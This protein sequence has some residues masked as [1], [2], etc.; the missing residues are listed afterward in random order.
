MALGRCSS[1]RRILAALL[2]VP[3][4]I[5][6]SSTSGAGVTAS[7]EPAAVGYYLSPDGDDSADGTTP[8]SAWRTLDRASQAVLAPGEHLWL[9]GGAR[10]TGRLLLDRQD[11]GDPA[12][13]VRI[14]SFGQGRAVIE[15]PDD[16]AVVV[17][18]AA[19]VQVRDLVLTGDPA[20]IR[21]GSAGVRLFAEARDAGVLEHVHVEGI[22][23]SGFDIGI[24][25]GASE[26]GA[27][28]R[29]VRIADADLHDNLRAGLASYGPPFDAAAPRYAHEDVVI[30]R[31]RAWNN[32]GDPEV[33]EHNTGSGIVLGS[34]RDAVVTA[35]VAHD[36]GGAGG[37][38]EGP[39]GIWTYDSTGVRIERSLSY[40]NRTGSLA[41]GGGFGLDQNTSDSVLQFNLSYDNHGPGYLVYTGKDNAAH[42]GSLVRFNV[43]SGD[44]RR[45]SVYGGITALG[46]VDDVVV[47]HNTVVMA[48][49]A[50]DP[51]AALRLGP[52]VTGVV[53][54]DNVFLVARAGPVVVAEG[55]AVDGVVL[56]GNVHH[57][58]GRSW[59]V[60]WGGVVHESVTAWRAATGQETRDGAPTGS[61]A[62]PLLAGPVL[63]LTA[64][65]AGDLVALAGFAPTA[66]SPL[67]GAAVGAGAGDRTPTAATDVRGTP[68]PAD[69]ADVGAVLFTG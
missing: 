2:C 37:A 60:V 56:Q 66:G 51:S 30:E 38:G 14:G 27:G 54:R 49:Q 64:S 35:S 65:A 53:V 43:S 33:T 55:S 4:L 15:A 40:R 21:R 16:A 8:E 58:T 50:T 25:L 12:R 47:E 57:A 34:L 44:A 68:V 42:R 29:D 26:P 24:E 6:C 69:A 22:E 52:G 20:G 62:D 3:A 32:V 19:G 10:F 67:R 61:D 48:P 39:I 63:G 46:R 45:W 18:D 31:V 59:A 5:G 41:D 23:A 13:P 17:L 11:G 36:N 1:S 28:F 7:G 9:Q